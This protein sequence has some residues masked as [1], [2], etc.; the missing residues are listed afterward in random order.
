MYETFSV[1]KNMPSHQKILK[2]TSNDGA[3]SMN[4]CVYCLF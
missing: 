1:N 4:N 3:V 2:Q